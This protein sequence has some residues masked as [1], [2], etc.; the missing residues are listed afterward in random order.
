[1]MAQHLQLLVIMLM[2]RQVAP[3]ALGFE[4]LLHSTGY[5]SGLSSSLWPSATA[6]GANAIASNQSTIAISTLVQI[7]QLQVELVL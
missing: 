5:S 2:L 7:L 4:L 1:M 3:T 6:L